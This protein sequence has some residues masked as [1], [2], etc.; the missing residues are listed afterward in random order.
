MP[1]SRDPRQDRRRRVLRENADAEAV[2][3][4]QGSRARRNSVQESSETQPRRSAGYS[5]DVRNACGH[6]LVQL[7]PIRRRSFAAVIGASFLIPALLLLAHYLVYVNGKLPWYGHPLA[8][9]LDAD[10]PQSVAAWFSSHLWL[11]CLGSTLLT[12]QLR[13]HKLDDYNGEYRLWF[14]LV[15]TCLIAS[16][17]ATTHVTE[18]FGAALHHWSQLNLGWSGPAVVKATL[19][20]LIGML[21]LRLCSELKV[22]PLSLCFWL[23]GL[24]AWAVSAALGPEELKIALTPQFRI[25]LRCAL[26]LGGLTAI[27]LSALTYLRHVY[28]EA[29]HR[30][31]LRG[32]LAA[33]KN[34]TPIGQR[35][36][37][38]LP[39][40]PAMPTLPSFRRKQLGDEL[41]TTPSSDSVRPRWAFPTLRRKT[42]A[43]A[44]IT[45]PQ[46]SRQKKQPNPAAPAVLST[47]T[48][49]AHPGEIPAERA[50]ANAS[51]NNTSGNNTSNTTTPLRPVTSTAAAIDDD[52]N[53]SSRRGLGR[54]LGR[55]GIDTT[56]VKDTGQPKQ[57]DQASTPSRFG[58]LR[59]AKDDDDAIEYRKLRDTEKEAA[60]QAR[61]A[62]KLQR[63]EEKQQAKSTGDNTPEKSTG[64]WLS[65]LPKLGKPKL[66]RVSIPKVKSLGTGWI[67][68]IKLPSFGLSALKLTPPE[69]TSAPQ[70]PVSVALRPVNTDRPLPGTVRQQDDDDEDEY[71]N[72]DNGRPMSKA[73][74]KRLRRQ[75]QQQNRAA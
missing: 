12:F 63:K 50:K 35:I 59:K 14:W 33:A 28:I 41:V 31:L 40:L 39:T 20:V 36:R 70:S 8:L 54:F 5:Q 57:A 29:Q 75:Q 42:T 64:R 19:T 44:S 52:H 27:W 71:D 62:E 55:K 30:F 56:S 73:E 6:R 16:V 3:L 4:T 49:A 74:R 45:E 34:A 43:D 60:R 17:D 51:G 22:V 21:G 10:H 32:R 69:D 48:S 65:K 1:I 18:L 25:W 13:R 15:I 26:W 24:V 23:V 68:K 37:E 47:A 67:P 46:V 2:E 7:I 72:E 61:T 38:S 58:W 11:L 66:P 53:A 9:A